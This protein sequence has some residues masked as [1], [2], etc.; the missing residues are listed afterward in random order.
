MC[1]SLLYLVKLTLVWPVLCLDTDAQ[2]L[3]QALRSAPASGI[4]TGTRSEVDSTVVAGTTLTTDPKS[5]VTV[6]EV[7]V[8]F[9]S[10]H[11]QI[12]C[13]QLTALMQTHMW[14]VDVSICTSN[15][16]I[17]SVFACR[18]PVRTCINTAS[19]VFTE[20]QFSKSS[21]SIRAGP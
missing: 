13:K 3:P 16:T 10:H 6:H 18:V 5:A 7:E 1:R 14:H 4:G 20:A 17:L 15:N 9:L 8:V 2:C 21:L 11:L 12:L 19:V